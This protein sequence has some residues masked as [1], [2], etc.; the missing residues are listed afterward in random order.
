[1]ASPSNTLCVEFIDYILLQAVDQ[2][3][4]QEISIRQL[5][6][7]FVKKT[8]RELDVRNISG[9]DIVGLKTKDNRYILNPSADFLLENASHVFALGTPKQINHLKDLIITRI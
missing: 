3:N 2:V 9:A 5:S 1:L 7:S 8:I 6:K 4:I